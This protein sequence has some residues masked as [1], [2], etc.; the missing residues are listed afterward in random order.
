MAICHPTVHDRE[1]SRRMGWQELPI[2]FLHPRRIGVGA[3]LL[4][5]L[6]AVLSSLSVNEIDPCPVAV[7]NR[8]TI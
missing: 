2:P 6:K 8:R 3:A 4:G 7:S 5:I 1:S